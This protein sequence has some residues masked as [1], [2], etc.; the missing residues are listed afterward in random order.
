MSDI[1]S[2]VLRV[3]LLKR[4]SSC[5]ERFFLLLVKILRDEMECKYVPFSNVP[6]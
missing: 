5:T 1:Y 6:H 2:T 3:L 4:G